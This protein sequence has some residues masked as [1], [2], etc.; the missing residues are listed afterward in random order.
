MAGICIHGTPAC[1]LWEICSLALCAF[2]KRR[3][4]AVSTPI[5]PARHRLFP[6]FDW[7]SEEA[8]DT[9]LSSRMFFKPASLVLLL[10]VC[11]QE[12]VG[13]AVPRNPSLDAGGLDRRQ[14]TVSSSSSVSVQ[15]FTEQ[16]SS[17]TTGFT[18]CR[19]AFK[20][21]TSVEVAYQ[22]VTT[23]YQTCQ[24]VATQY[25]SC[26]TCARAGSASVSTFK[27]GIEIDF[28][29]W[30]EIIS[31]GQQRYAAQWKSKFASTFQRFDVW[32]KAANTA[33]SSFNLQLGSIVSGL[34]IDL[35]LF[36]G[37]NINIGGILGISLGGVLGGILK[38]NSLLL[39]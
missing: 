14:T 22:S 23:L 10:A 39:E 20:S 18:S 13:N 31:I 25:P 8:N 33:C 4:A 7:V 37:I 38:R 17:V 26:A 35:N 6:A 36:L 29:T 5:C 12:A 19:D 9:L 30:H 34:G 21:T 2:I 24:R 1:P 11:F 16:W 28:K 15:T 32:V 3:L 27:S